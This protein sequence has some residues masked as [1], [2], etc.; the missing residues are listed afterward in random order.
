MALVGVL[1][2]QLLY[3]HFVERFSDR[4]AE[5]KKAPLR[6]TVAINRRGAEVCATK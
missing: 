4:V 6:L 5:A 1:S 2:A 3:H